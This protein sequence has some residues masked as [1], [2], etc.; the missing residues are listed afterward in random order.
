M[1]TLDD[2]L[3][4][5]EAQSGPSG[6]A[7][8]GAVAAGEA[9]EELIADGGVDAGTV[10]VHAQHGVVTL[11]RDAQGDPGARR[12]VCPGV[13]EKVRDDLVHPTRIADD[14]DGL[15]RHLDA[16]VVVGRRRSRIR[17]SFERQLGEVDGAVDQ[18]LPL[19][20]PCEQQQ[21]LDETGHPQGLRLDALER[22]GRAFDDLRTLFRGRTLMQRAQRQLRVPPDGRERGAQLVTRVGDEAAHSL[23]VLLPRGQRGVDV[24]EE[25]VQGSSDETGLGARIGFGCRYPLGDRD[26]API[27]LLVRD[28][29]RGDRDGAERAQAH[30]DGDRGGQRQQ[31]QTADGGEGDHGEQ[32]RELALDLVAGEP[33]DHDDAVGRGQRHNPVRAEIGE[34]HGGD[35]RALQCQCDLRQLRAA[36]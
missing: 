36:E 25:L 20:E 15:V 31:D 29:G 27:E 13:R 23:L 9:R 19:V 6:L 3:D 14:R 22:G 16:P 33:G 35:R 30:P 18:L 21:V 12:R 2:G 11:P 32:L 34:G 1:V 7:R 4:D 17:E 28:P 10:I 24:I 8:P 26:L 5:R